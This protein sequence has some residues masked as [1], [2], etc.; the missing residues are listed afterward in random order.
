M[1]RLAVVTGASAGIGR[2]VVESLSAEN[3]H[4][5]AIARR[6]ERLSGWT[7]PERVIPMA[8][9]VSDPEQV[10][11]TVSRIL[12]HHDGID[13]LVNCAGNLIDER[14]EEVTLEAID[15]QVAVNFL[16]TLLLCQACLPGLR[17]RNGAIVNFSSLITA[18]PVAGAS[19]Y[20]ATK[21]AVEGFSKVIAN[22]LAA[23]GIRVFVLSPSLVRSEIYTAAGM[24]EE[25]YEEM[26]QE[27]KVRFPLGRVGEP[28]DVASLVAF[29]LSDRSSWMTGLNIAVDGGR[30]VAFT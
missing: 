6:P 23:D 2:A 30:G 1:G 20:A 19:V 4:L 15:R 3:Y 22:E 27:W 29:L 11:E 13:G 8:C 9:D 18:R 28:E 5:V 21:G 17:R 26:L 7:Y 25:A 10:R 12:E 14:L 24:S 16:G